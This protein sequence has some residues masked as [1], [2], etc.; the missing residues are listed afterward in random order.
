MA[1]ANDKTPFW[2]YPRT[3]LDDGICYNIR[4]QRK[5]KHADIEILEEH[6][7]AKSDPTF[8]NM[9]FVH[10]EPADQ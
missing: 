3:S 2:T 6:P 10:R 5:A 8:E 1:V 9:V 4:D 7:L